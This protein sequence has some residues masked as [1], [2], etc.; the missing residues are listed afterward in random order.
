MSSDIESVGFLS[1]G[2]AVLLNMLTSDNNRDVNGSGSQSSKNLPG[3]RRTVDGEALLA[4]AN[5]KNQLL[6]HIENRGGR[7][8]QNPDG[9]TIPWYTLSP[10]LTVVN[11]F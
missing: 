6:Y 4:G 2:P 10:G 11:A 1:G 5:T 9:E 8:L 7:G 3:N